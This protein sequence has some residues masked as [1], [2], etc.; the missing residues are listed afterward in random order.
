MGFRIPGMAELMVGL[1]LVASRL[2]RPALAAARVCNG[3]AAVGGHSAHMAA[4]PMGTQVIETLDLTIPARGDYEVKPEAFKWNGW[5][6]G[7]DQPAHVSV[8]ITLAGVVLAP[9]WRISGDWV[10]GGG[11]GCSSKREVGFRNWP[12][13]EPFSV[14]RLEEGTYALELTYTFE[15]GGCACASVGLDS[16]AS[17]SGC[18]P[19]VPG[20]NV[21]LPVTEVL[22]SAQLRRRNRRTES[23]TVGDSED[24]DAPTGTSTVTSTVT[25]TIESTATSTIESTATST[26]A[27]E[28]TPTAFAST[29]STTATATETTTQFGFALGEEWFHGCGGYMY[30][31][32]EVAALKK[33]G[34]WHVP[35]K[36]GK[37]CV[38]VQR[39]CDQSEQCSDGSDEEDCDSTMGRQ[40]VHALST[41]LDQL[42]VGDAGYGR[43]AA[44]YHESLD[45]YQRMLKIAAG[46]QPSASKG[47]DPVKRH[48]WAVA[49]VFIALFISGCI[50]YFLSIKRFLENRPPLPYT[51]RAALQRAGISTEGFEREN[52]AAAD[53]AAKIAKAE[54]EAAAPVVDAYQEAFGVN[55]FGFGDMGDEPEVFAGFGPKEEAAATKIQASFRGHQTRRR[56]SSAGEEEPA[57][58]AAVA[59]EKETF[60]GFGAKGAPAVGSPANTSPASALAMMAAS[61]EVYS[62]I[63]M[64][65]TNEVYAI[66]IPSVAVAAGAEPAAGAN[67][68]YAIGMPPAAPADDLT[69]VLQP[70]A[71]A[72]LSPM[73]ALNSIAAATGGVALALSNDVYS[74]I[75]MPVTNEVYEI[76][77]PP[78]A[79]AASSTA[80]AQPAANEVYAVGMP[81]PVAAAD[82]LTMVIEPP[83]AAAAPTN[84]PSDLPAGAKEARGPDLGGEEGGEA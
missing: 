50:G 15:G 52:L 30:P 24:S 17:L 70:P 35:C 66:G 72:P 58:A 4:A 71:N 7:S 62:P 18:P 22:R 84:N 69:M 42:N 14:G 83:S 47:K 44:A 55:S 57:A 32:G 46:E 56:L 16:G 73:S 31:G 26:A 40:V 37:Q 11:C 64:P 27:S 20:G 54:Q 34:A 43:A 68:V 9:S 8:R 36:D 80:G 25:S 81:P 65:V 23:D 75:D 82:D 48:G 79:A 63:D 77:I 67:E 49:A 60:D 29:A 19:E 74:P 3:A 5:F 59:S 53:A 6:A 1:A 76:G 78:A 21:D 33:D 61:N 45:V 2:G 10:G 12:P 51:A 28:P 13:K 41:S 39:W 38:D